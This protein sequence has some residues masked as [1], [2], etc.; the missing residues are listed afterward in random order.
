MTVR[1]LALLQWL[2][3][4]VGG[5]AW[6][7]SFLTGVGT[8]TAVCNPASGRWGIPHDAVEIGITAFACAAIAA[9]EVASVV[10]FR[11][12]RGVAEDA[13]PPQGRI[14]FF[15]SAA[16]VANVVFFM[17]ILLAGIATVVNRT[18]HQS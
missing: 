14:H 15:A 17:V 4:L 1:R 13:P 5:I 9:A 7:G 11:A 3:I 16:L 12:T 8:A 6:F 2:G 18:C 10:V